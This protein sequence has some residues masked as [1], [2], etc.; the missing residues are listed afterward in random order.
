MSDPYRLVCGVCEWSA[1]TA[2]GTA[3]MAVTNAGIAHYRETDHTPIQAQS[4]TPSSRRSR[5]LL[6]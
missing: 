5:S 4:Y 2:D 3:R 1:T 6:Q